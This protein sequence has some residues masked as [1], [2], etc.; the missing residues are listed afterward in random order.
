MSHLVL[1]AAYPPA[2]VPP[3]F[4]GVMGYIG[5][6]RATHVWSLAEWLPFSGMRQFPCY[7]PDLGSGPGPQARDAV[8][9]AAG[10]GWAAYMPGDGRRVIVFDLE[11]GQYPAWYAAAAAVVTSAGF[12]PV[13]YGSMSS[14][15]GNEAYANIAAEWDGIDKIPAGQTLHGVQYAANVQLEGAKVDYSVFDSWLFNRGGVGPRHA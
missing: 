10:L 1:D 5:G 6:A 12:M 2:H 9:R 15:F 14:V 13:C 4:S 3:E 7:V 8:G 11:T